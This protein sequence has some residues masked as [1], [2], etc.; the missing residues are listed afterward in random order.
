[1][2]VRPPHGGLCLVSVHSAANHARHAHNA[3]A[4]S[5]NLCPSKVLKATSEI[6]PSRMLLGRLSPQVE[7]FRTSLAGHHL[8]GE[9]IEASVL[10]E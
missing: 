4:I 2:E 7:L 8:P 9:V 1:M 3:I 10:K 6:C 5:V